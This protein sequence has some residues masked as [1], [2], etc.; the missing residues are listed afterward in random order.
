MQESKNESK[1]KKKVETSG[2]HVYEKPSTKKHKPMDIVIGSHG[3]YGYTYYYYYYYYSLYY[4]CWVAREVYGTGNPK[5]I[6]FRD[7]MLNR[8]PSW[9][10]TLYLNH[11]TSFARFISNKPRLKGIIRRWMDSRIED[12]ILINGDVWCVS[13]VS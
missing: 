8:A 12:R 1:T 6:I 3:G 11:G 10:R 9:F 7:W 2:A 13:T 4:S 5:W